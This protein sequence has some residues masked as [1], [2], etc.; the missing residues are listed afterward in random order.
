MPKGLT[1]TDA[2]KLLGGSGPL[3]TIAD[4]LLGGALSVAT[5]G[6][7]D[8]AL[9]LFDAKAE[10][11]RLGHQVAA[12]LSDSVRG[13][14][15]YDRTVRLQAAHGVLVVTAF[16]EALDVCLTEA[17][18][19]SPEF[20]RDEQ[21]RLS[22]VVSS[23]VAATN[24]VGFLK[25]SPIPVPAPERGYDQLLAELTAW[26]ALT[27]T[28]A[29][30]FLNGLAILADADETTQRT[31][32]QSLERA[33]ER[34]AA[35]YDESV[36]R[37]ALEIPEFG[38]WLRQLED[39]ATARGL[40]ALEV[41]L[42]ETTS[43][44][45]P[46]RQRAALA[47]AYRAVLDRPILGGDAGD[48]LIP[49]LATA[50]IDPRFRVRP[51]GPGA[52]PAEES[53]WDTADP[54]G[55]FAGFLATYL[56][57]P[58]AAEAP[59]VLLGHPGAGKS[60]LTRILAARL[61][62]ADYLVVRVALRDVRAEA[63]IQDQIEQ[64]LRTTIG[65]TV[66]WAD[67]TR[68]A[69]GAMPVLLLDGFDELLQ[70]TGIHQSD[71][72]HR[73][74]AFQERE[75]TLGRPVAVM[76]TSRVAVADRARLPTGALAVRL[77]AFDDAQVARWLE[78]WNSI[79]PDRRPVP[80]AALHRFPDLAA[81]P[82][83][84]LMLALYDASGHRLPDEEN[85]D[86]GQLYERLLS[87]FARREVR[88]LHPGLAESHLPALI[89]AELL[90][91][92]VVAFAMFHRLRLWATTEELDRDLAGLGLHPATPA[93]TEDFRTPLTAGQEMVGRF[94]F[95]QR[96]QAR[97]DD[98][99]LQTYEFLHATFGEYL[100]ARLVVQAVRD[101]AARSQAR[102]LHIGPANDD[103]LLQSLLGFTPLT[104]RATILPFIT[105]LL[106]RPD[107]AQT[108]EWLVDR[109][110]TAVTRPQYT[111]RRYQPID[112]RIDHWMATYSFNLM[113]L[114]LACGGPLPASELFQHAKDPAA[115]LRDTSLQWRAAVPSG[116]WLDTVATITV[117]REW[118]T[119]SRRDLI[120]NPGEE[121]DGGMLWSHNFAPDSEEAGWAPGGVFSDYF[122]LAPALNSMR[123]SGALSDDMLR[124]ALDPLLRR[125]PDTVL[126][127]VIQGPGE[128]EPVAASLIRM[129]LASS[130][131]DEPAALLTAYERA[132]RTVAR[133]GW[134]APDLEPGDRE[135][136][137]EAIL[138]SLTRDAH[139]L[140]PPDVVRLVD[141]IIRHGYGDPGLV[142]ACLAGLPD[143][144]PG[145]GDLRDA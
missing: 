59:M 5:A 45:G 33:P 6:G 129:F 107:P 1:Y 106:R 43:Q 142:V 73:V 136:N 49:S 122:E 114:T 112:K 53:W 32:A 137:T 116:I 86:T 95:I 63:E 87:E 80:L 40:E 29:Q 47:T 105:E 90:R 79:N 145:L 9:S 52:R 108:R 58:Q 128:L 84:L 120:L 99:T 66:S 94:F 121:C 135:P 89:D 3:I 141:G 92:S 140:S 17:G 21:L 71:Y 46:Q 124:S 38:F 130:L 68:D 25:D 96:A 72:L 55:D 62:A 138:R 48:V 22:G 51:A 123:L 69:D 125:L 119:D 7:S 8:V 144:T 74:A 16:F 118:T 85:L 103:D 131:A 139:R 82:L 42:H 126:S 15:R 100:I 13:L 27:R 41:A 61:P 64:A 75:S 30:V 132:V 134:R 76:V 70:V 11:I 88:R 101:A 50:Y 67:L 113:L 26:F 93:R 24:L 36:R 143:D 44:R 98:R 115:W 4:N 34:A 65:E 31:V 12:K 37:L 102:S 18:L 78:I 28:K 10:A 57:T 35:R 19:G 97:Q 54:R 20:T 60:S 81:Q 104:T 111:E 117:S 39:R 91:L 23:P 133:F 109:L 14:G 56:T 127:V 83:L 77:E 110:R 2:V